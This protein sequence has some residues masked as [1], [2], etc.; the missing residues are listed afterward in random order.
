MLH[1]LTDIPVPRGLP[2]PIWLL[3]REC[4][5]S[6]FLSYELQSL[7][8]LHLTNPR[9]VYTHTAHTQ[10][11]RTGFHWQPCLLSLD[12]NK[13]IRHKKRRLISVRGIVNIK[14]EGQL[15]SVGSKGDRFI[16]ASMPLSQSVLHFVIWG[17]TSCAGITSVFLCVYIL[18]QVCC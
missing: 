2:H 8:F 6:A 18:L 12:R 17:R 13:L 10:L 15:L 3:I 16:I 11:V 1:A 5:D 9:P 14:L 7:L 4:A